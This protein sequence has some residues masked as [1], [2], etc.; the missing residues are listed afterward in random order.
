[1]LIYCT[2]YDIGGGWWGPTSIFF[3]GAPNPLATALYHQYSSLLW[4]DFN[5]DVW[6][7]VKLAKG[8]W[9]LNFWVNNRV[10]HP[11]PLLLFH[12]EE[13]FFFFFVVCQASAKG[14][15]LQSLKAGLMIN[16]ARVGFQ[17]FIDR[18]YKRLLF[19]KREQQNRVHKIKCLIYSRQNLLHQCVEEEQIHINDTIRKSASNMKWFQ[20]RRGLKGSTIFHGRIVHK[21]GKW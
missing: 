14:L 17:Q 15:L 12:T 1:M 2:V 3:Q 18:F 5:W 8:K 4:P 20:L 21:K 16:R 6:V 10:K 19:T 7:C 11:H 9:K 13:R